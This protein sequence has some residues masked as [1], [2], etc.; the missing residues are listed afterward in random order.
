[1]VKTHIILIKSDIPSHRISLN[2]FYGL[3]LNYTHHVHAP[4]P[5]EI[6][7]LTSYTFFVARGVLRLSF[8]QS[9]SI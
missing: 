5:T 3:P 1:M 4:S 2:P 6:L 8:T 7:C 9:S